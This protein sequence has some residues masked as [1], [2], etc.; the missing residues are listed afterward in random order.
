M[1]A[2]TTATPS[3]TNPASATTTSQAPAV[4]AYAS[5]NAAQRL[6]LASMIQDTNGDKVF[7]NNRALCGFIKASEFLMVTRNTHNAATPKVDVTINNARA[8]VDVPNVDLKILGGNNGISNL[9]GATGDTYRN[10]TTY[11]Y[12]DD[13]IELAKIGYM[14]YLALRTSGLTRQDAYVASALRARWI[15]LGAYY[16][17]VLTPKKLYDEVT[18]IDPDPTG[19]DYERIAHATSM[20]AIYAIQPANASEFI[21]EALSNESG[22][23]WIVG[24]AE[25]IWTAVEFIVRVR[26]HHWKD[27]YEITY[28]KFLAA[29]FQDAHDIPQNLS[30]VHIFR[31][32]IHPFGLRTLAI[33]AGHFASHGKV[34]NSALIRFSG[35]PNGMAICTT[36]KAALDALKGETWYN[37]FYIAFKNQVDLLDAVCEK[38]MSD[39]YTFHLSHNIYGMV[40]PIS[41]TINGKN[42]T[43][44]EMRQVGAAMAPNAQGFIAA[45]E[46]AKNSG[47]INAFSMSNAKCTVKHAA[48]NPL[49]AARL[50]A[51]IEFAIDNI[52][53]AKS[54]EEATNAVLPKEVKPAITP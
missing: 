14:N 22:I 10:A 50:R 41:V 12:I 38:I 44:E 51:L 29:Y 3:S 47:Y 54:L 48:N 9:I 5:L 35:A 49:A 39:K 42:Y 40:Q 25:A 36:C 8:N 33:M 52:S 11:L 24:H 26:G 19:T 46:G 1:S 31:T 15:A 53:V 18:I 28:T 20:D 13:E 30:K 2:S 21:Q 27:D 43:I 45:M 17:Y 16:A 32:A 23:E 6:L 34:A 37:Q 7:S 4:N